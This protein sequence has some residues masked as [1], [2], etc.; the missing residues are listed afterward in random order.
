MSKNK[1]IIILI[2]LILISVAVFF[3]FFFQK[4]KTEFGGESFTTGEGIIT[5]TLSFSG[6]VSSVDVEN[7]FL[8]VKTVNEE[9]KVVVSE[10][11]K[12]IELKAPFS[13]DNPPSAGTQF[14]PEK[15]EIILSDFEEGDE[16]LVISEEDIIGKSEINNVSLVQILP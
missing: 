7:S 2:V 6:I 14:V 10:T 12:L 1:I 16:V 5:Q 3:F 11:T 9:F 13:P 15:K 8:T 4:E